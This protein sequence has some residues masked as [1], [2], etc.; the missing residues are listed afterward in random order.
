[1][2]HAIKQRERLSSGWD[3]D[4]AL[5]AMR[6]LAA[7]DL[8]LLVLTAPMI[9]GAE[10]LTGTVPRALCDELALTF[11]GTFAAL[12]GFISIWRKAGA[13]PNSHSL[14]W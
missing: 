10:Y 12:G 4:A 13:T 7:A 3:E 1:M 5:P 6:P 2:N 11:A 8:A 9:K 14:S